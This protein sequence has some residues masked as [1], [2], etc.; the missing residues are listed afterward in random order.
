MRAAIVSLV[1]LTL[2]ASPVAAAS[3]ESSPTYLILP[4]ENIAEEPSLGWL[5]PCLAFSFGEYFIGLGARVIEADERAVLYEGSG[6]PDGA[7]LM[8]ASALELGRKL[9]SRPSTNRP[10]RMVLG[11]FLITEGA[12][13]ISARSIDLTDEKSGPRVSRDGRLTDLLKMLNRVA[14]DI[15]SRDGIDLPMTRSAF[16]QKHAG[17][18][19]LLAFETYCR[20]M[21]ET[22]PRV[23]LKGLR[24]AVREHPGYP[25][26]IYHAVRL[27]A[28]AERWSEAAKMIDRISAEPH[29]YEADFHLTAAGV[30]L[31]QRE[32]E[33]AAEAARR[34]L[35]YV[36]SPQGHLLLARAHLA[37]GDPGAA[38]TELDAAEELDPS[39]PGLETLRRMLSE[40]TP[41]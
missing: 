29:P 12:L 2:L 10:G 25:K 19:P 5:S 33:K 30:A 40:K 21:A 32:A 35:E 18:V 16:L 23:K 7:P 36:E 28:E 22:D 4:F 9:R 1:A 38:R 27:L 13:T 11:R 14:L 26:A 8:L 15:A 41:G 3:G 6:L 20:S 34:A 37:N 39:A 24:R 17:D 31:E